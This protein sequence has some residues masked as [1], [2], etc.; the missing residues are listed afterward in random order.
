MNSR[1]VVSVIVG[2]VIFLTTIALVT[3]KA[4]Q[5]IAW[6]W[7]V[8]MLPMIMLITFFIVSVIIVGFIIYIFDLD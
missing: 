2:A 1:G 8:V 3:L 7:S 5:V 4:A 6:P